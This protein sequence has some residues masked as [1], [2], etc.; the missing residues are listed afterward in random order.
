MNKTVSA[1]KVAKE[2]TR[3]ELLKPN[4]S[5]MGRLRQFP[6]QNCRR[7]L[8]MISA[9]Y[10]VLSVLT[11][12]LGK[13]KPLH[14]CWPYTIQAKPVE[15]LEWNPNNPGFEVLTE[16]GAIP[17]SWWKRDFSGSLWQSQEL[18]CGGNS[19]CVFRILKGDSD[20]TQQEHDKIR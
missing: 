12:I 20:L 5:N 15:W 8:S 1:S 13:P 18:G 16:L 11:H 17:R 10:P 2:D 4:L 9:G 14:S 3:E 7:N 6:S 19:G